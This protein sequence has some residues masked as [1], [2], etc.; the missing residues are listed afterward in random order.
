MAKSSIEWTDSTWNPVTGCTKIST[1][2]KNCYAL[3]VSMR[4]QAMG[5]ANY[6]NG[7]QL[8]LHSS[9]L[10]R[11]LSWK[12]PQRIFVNSMSDLF[13]DDVP[14]EYIIQVFDVMRRASWHQFQVLTKRAERLSALAS[15]LIW[16]SNVWM[17]VSVESQRYT[18]RIDYLRNVPAVIRFV[19]F[20]PLVGAI[21]A[22]DLQ[23]IHWAIIGGESGPGA[24]PMREEWVK[25][26]RDLCAQHGTAFFFKQWGGV[27]KSKT[28]RMLDGRTWDALP[29]PL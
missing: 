16:P 11:P 12:K 9:M 6:K 19:S 13:H 29:E 26:L 5:A 10:D 28:G 3:R 21:T 4:L 18:S 7:F 27:I 14:T 22:A 1:G 24:R 8:S 25:R 20:E 17:G 2:C 15:K 23:D